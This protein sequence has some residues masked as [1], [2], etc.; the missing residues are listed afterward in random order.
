MVLKK[1]IPSGSRLAEWG[2]MML[3]GLVLILLAVIVVLVTDSDCK[4]LCSLRTVQRFHF[5]Y[6]EIECAY[7]RQRCCYPDTSFRKTRIFGHLCW[8]NNIP[9]VQQSATAAELACS[10]S[11]LSSRA[12]TRLSTLECSL[13]R[14]VQLRLASKYE[15][16]IFEIQN[17]IAVING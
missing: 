17:L 6:D 2:R 7:L 15:F 16:K 14:G 5:L 4:N 10:I 12:A 8:Q 3:V 11:P 9:D 13:G 1:V